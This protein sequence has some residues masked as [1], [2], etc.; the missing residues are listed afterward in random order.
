VIIPGI[1]GMS[2]VVAYFQKRQALLRRQQSRG[3]AS[4][5]LIEEEDPE[6]ELE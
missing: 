4:Q 2:K 1:Y 5:E 6:E 3:R